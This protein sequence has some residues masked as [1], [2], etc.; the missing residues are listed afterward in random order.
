MNIMPRMSYRLPKLCFE[1]EKEN[2]YEL[3]WRKDYMD[4]DLDTQG[5]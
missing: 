2:Y 5:W 3:Q 1:K 4:I